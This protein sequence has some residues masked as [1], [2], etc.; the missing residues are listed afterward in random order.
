MTAM[1]RRAHGH[2]LRTGGRRH[3]GSSPNDDR[4]ALAAFARPTLPYDANRAGNLLTSWT[5][6]VDAA[7]RLDAAQASKYALLTSIDK[8]FGASERIKSPHG[9]GLDCAK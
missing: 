5:E 4:N 2:K 6:S 1:T 7:Q 9:Y 8:D 3:G